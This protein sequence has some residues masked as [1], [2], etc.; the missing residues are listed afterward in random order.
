LLGRERVGERRVVV[1]GCTVAAVMVRGVV[2]SEKSPAN[3][4][5]TPKGE[6]SGAPS[7]PPKE[8]LGPKTAPPGADGGKSKRTLVFEE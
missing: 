1:M 3:I 6:K 7:K 4:Y 8:K 2:L 5:T